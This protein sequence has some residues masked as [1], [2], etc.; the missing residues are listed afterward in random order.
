MILE[1]AQRSCLPRRRLSR[2]ACRTSR[3]ACA[4]REVMKV[5]EWRVAELWTGSGNSGISAG[6]RGRCERTERPGSSPGLERLDMYCTGALGLHLSLEMLVMETRLRTCA[7]YTQCD[8]WAGDGTK[9]VGVVSQHV[10]EAA[11]RTAGRCLVRYLLRTDGSSRIIL[12]NSACLS[13]PG[14]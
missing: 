11:R 14:E 13:D 3:R 1:G 9:S 4:R 7:R 5:S 10:P 2:F 6:L 8:P 12:Y